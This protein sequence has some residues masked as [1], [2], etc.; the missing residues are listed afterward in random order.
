MFQHRTRSFV[1][2]F[3][4]IAI[5][6]PLLA[7]PQGA[8]RRRDGKNRARPSGAVPGQAGQ[9]MLTDFN[10]KLK[11]IQRGI[12]I[13]TRDD[14]T[15]V[16]VQPPEDISSFQFVAEAKPQF[17]RPGMLVRFSGTF[18]RA[19]V[20]Q[21]PIAKVELFQQLSAKVP[22]NKRKFFVPGVH[23]DR[24]D[25]KKQQDTGIARCD[26]VGSLVGID[27]SGVM[28]VRAGKVPVRM[29]LVQNATF[30]IRYNNL[31]LAQPGDAVKVSGFYNPPDETKVAAGSFV[32]TTDRVYGEPIAEESKKNV[33]K[34]RT[35]RRRP[36][37]NAEPGEKT[38][39][40]VSGSGEEQQAAGDADAPEEKVEPDGEAGSAGETTTP[41]TST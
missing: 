25:M 7:D 30:E 2:V 27:Q 37:K 8:N 9:N 17:L 21:S 4:I 28:M 3:L 41:S 13:V 16:M 18:D 15:D 22:P 23:P 24:R 33:R 10:G 34:H 26:V 12:M 1:A 40:G 5:A 20:A 6:T 36:G 29:P 35:R 19:G 39:E 14:G 31:S 32:I 38:A 11:A